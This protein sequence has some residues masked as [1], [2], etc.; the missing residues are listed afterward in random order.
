MR[1]TWT[2]SRIT[3]RLVGGYEWS[4]ATQYVQEVPAGLAAELLTAPEP[5][6]VAKDEPLLTLRGVGPHTVGLLALGGVGSVADLAALDATEI[7]QVAEASGLSRT[8]IRKW[9]T[10]ARSMSEEEQNG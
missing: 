3:R 1:I 4:Q 10:V 5:F 6:A 2:G 7:R 8:Q 9:A